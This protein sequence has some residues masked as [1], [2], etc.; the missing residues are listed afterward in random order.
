MVFDPRP[1]TEASSPHACAAGTADMREDGVCGLADGSDRHV[2]AVIINRDLPG[3]K[4]LEW[5]REKAGT[6]EHVHDEIK[7]ELA[8]LCVT[9]TGDCEPAIRQ[10][11][12]IVGFRTAARRHPI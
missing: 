4:V 3:D 9:D 7:N 10:A 2:H 11:G 1:L 6:V 8:G 5:H 12:N